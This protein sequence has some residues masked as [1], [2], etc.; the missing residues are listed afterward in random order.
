ML[1]INTTWS[2]ESQ[3]GQ[4]ASI[5]N[6]SLIPLTE[7][8][9]YREA[10]YA[11]IEGR[12][13]LLAHRTN[14]T[15]RFVPKIDPNGDMVVTKKAG[16]GR[17]MYAQERRVFNLS[18]EYAITDISDITEF[19]ELM[20]YNKSTFEWKKFTEKIKLPKPEEKKII[21]P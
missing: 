8:C 2:V 5:P 9:P 20:A 4:P 12:L 7:D 11:P 14:E 6:F 17:G 1:L 3:T 15:F 18:N 21:L 10:I 19:I 16:E 13:V